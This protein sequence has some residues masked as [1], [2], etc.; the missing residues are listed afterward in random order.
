MFDKFK[1]TQLI[2]IL[3]STTNIY[4]YIFLNI[5][6]F[7]FHFIFYCVHGF[8]FCWRYFYVNFFLKT[9]SFVKEINFFVHVGFFDF[10]IR[11]QQYIERK[12]PG[13]MLKVMINYSAKGQ[14]RFANPRVN[15][16]HRSFSHFSK[17]IFEIISE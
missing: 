16:F 8:V 12:I 1:F 14:K 11:I 7:I 17:S 9:V 6:G 15:C 3:I 2:K 5:G 10:S 4:I 13:G